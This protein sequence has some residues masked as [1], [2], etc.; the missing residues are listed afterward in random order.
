M[1]IN[2][3]R[4]VNF[5]LSFWIL[6]KVGGLALSQQPQQPQQQRPVTERTSQG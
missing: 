6:L 3:S 2:R 4:A 1:F 5:L